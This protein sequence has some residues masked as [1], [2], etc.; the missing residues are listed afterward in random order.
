MAQD[1]A[2]LCLAVELLESNLPEEEALL[3]FPAL[4]RG[5]FL[6]FQLEPTVGPGATGFQTS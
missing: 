6:E 1:G 2:I 5:I 4:P 3:A